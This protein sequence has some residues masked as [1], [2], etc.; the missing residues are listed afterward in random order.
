M[1]RFLYGK[2]LWNAIA[3]RSEKA[4]RTKAA[5]AYVTRSQPL[6]FKAGDVLIVDASEGAIAS[7]QTS[8]AV[9]STLLKNGVA[10]YSH[11]GLHAK[12]V[13]VDG[14]LFTSSANLSESSLARL[15][16]A[17]VETDNPNVVSAAAGMIERL[18]EKSTKIDR[19]FISRINKIKVVKRFG[20][21]KS[22][23]RT[24][25]KGH[26]EP[27]TWLVGVRSI[28]ESTNPDEMSRIQTGAA[29]AEQLLSNPESSAEWIRHAR[30]GRLS[31]ARQDDNI[32]LIDRPSNDGNPRR[33][34]RHALI[35]LVQD[36]PNCMRI[37]YEDLPN[38]E[39]QSLS[40]AQ[41]KKLAKRVGLP[42][43]VS[44]NS[45][46]QLTDKVSTDLHDNWER[47]RDK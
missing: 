37:F 21:A 35:R 31:E 20:G 14:T 34:Y 5:I 19:V 42:S 46:R 7:G 2:L 29:M 18:I 10:L 25:P 15:L 26:R 39:E 27:V 43:N 44:K 40:W 32:I 41:F 4:H 24:P 23:A 3:V 12:V 17:G 38:S 47:V 11:N 9:L 22:E 8:G 36:E 13:V 45:T 28:A 1:T 6:S 16:E 30:T 33:V